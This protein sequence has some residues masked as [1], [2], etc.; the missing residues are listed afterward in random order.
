[1]HPNGAS[2]PVWEDSVVRD[3]DM[4]QNRT[5]EQ[6][7]ERELVFDG[8]GSDALRA[9]L[10]DEAANFVVPLAARAYDEHVAVEER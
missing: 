5:S 9:L 3:G 8:W 4:A 1:M 10:E 6:A 7:P 2:R